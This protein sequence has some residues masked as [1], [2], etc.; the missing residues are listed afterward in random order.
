MSLN[1]LERLRDNG[2]FTFDMVRQEYVTEGFAVSVN[3]E[4]TRRV[5]GPV[6][7]ITLLDYAGRNVSILTSGDKVLGAWVDT[8]T[9]TTYLDVVTIVDDK[10]KALELA[11][12]HGEIAI[13]DLTTQ[14][15]IRTDVTK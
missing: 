8:E 6:D 15:E 7:A 11:V 5:R 2:G 14:T 3:P 1:M 10:A 4:L 12:E 9:G 13:Y